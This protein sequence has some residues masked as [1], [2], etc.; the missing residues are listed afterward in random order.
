MDPDDHQFWD[1]LYKLIKP[2]ATVFKSYYCHGV[3]GGPPVEIQLGA[4][5]VWT[6]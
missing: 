3:Q 5:T 6:Q 2:A 1:M 4:L